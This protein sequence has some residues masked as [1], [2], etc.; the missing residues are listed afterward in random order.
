MLTSICVC[1]IKSP[2]LHVLSV[3]PYHCKIVAASTMSPR[4]P[5]YCVFHPQM[6]QLRAQ[7]ELSLLTLN[8]CLHASLEDVAPPLLTNLSTLL[9]SISD[10]DNCK[11]FAVQTPPHLQIPPG[12]NIFLVVGPL[13]ER[14]GKEHPIREFCQSAFDHSWVY[15]VF[16]N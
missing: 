16:R 4:Y 14:V 13:D 5:P 3:W 12:N 10:E 2:S 8:Q 7:H 9:S 1:N 11:V 6:E 15:I